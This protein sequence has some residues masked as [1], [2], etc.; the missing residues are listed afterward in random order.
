M[1]SP[2]VKI[3][4][5]KEEFHRLAFTDAGFLAP[6]A[7]V[8]FV[9]GSMPSMLDGNV[10]DISMSDPYIGTFEGVAHEVAHVVDFVRRGKLKR[11]T[12]KNFGLDSDKVTSKTGGCPW[13][14]INELHAFA[15][16]F[17]IMKAMME[18]SLHKEF[19]EYFIGD[20]LP[21]AIDDLAFKEDTIV[22][23]NWFGPDVLRTGHLCSHA[24]AGI[25]NDIIQNTSIQMIRKV[26][27]DFIRQLEKGVVK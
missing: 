26:W 8:R 2:K 17:H 6:E 20:Y 5:Y 3:D 16:E 15:Y 21:L 13:G 25:V 18:R 9:R 24:M 19:R 7:V 22:I 23:S 10:M 11:L 27:N 1:N 12:K 14:I 4:H